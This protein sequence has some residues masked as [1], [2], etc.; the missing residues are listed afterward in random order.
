MQREI[1]SAYL[2]NEEIN[3][4]KNIAVALGIL[5]SGN[6]TVSAEGW[7][8]NADWVDP[9]VGEQI[10]IAFTTNDDG[11]SFGL[12]RSEDGRVRAIYSLPESTFDR[13]P[14]GGRVLMIRPGSNRSIEIEAEIVQNSITERAKSNGIS[15]RSLIWHGEGSSPAVGTLRNVLDSEEMF[16]R[17]FTETGPTIDTSWSMDGAHVVIEQALGISSVVSANEQEWAILEM[18]AITSTMNRCFADGRKLECSNSLDACIELL[19]IDRNVEGF[20]VCFAS[21]SAER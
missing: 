3:L 8:L 17:F 7:Q 5:L 14:K 10:P 20:G 6:T 18:E 19:V 1:C 11:F 16:A 15:V 2:V 4:I 9:F 21:R 12:F 13:I